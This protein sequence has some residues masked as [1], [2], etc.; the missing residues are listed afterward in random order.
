[1]TSNMGSHII[2]ENF[3]HA[4]KDNI[5]GVVESTKI[6]V[7]DLLKKTIR[8]EFLNRIDE[9]IMFRP[10][11]KN[12]IESIVRIQ[13]DN[14]AKM[15]S[16][17][18]VNVR[19]TDEVVSALAAQGYEPEFGARPLK[20]VLQREVINQLSKYILAGKVDRE[21]QIVIDVNSSG[22]IVFENAGHEL[23]S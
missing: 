7:M 17:T 1:M 16:E 21:A 15:L 19:F 12:S 3:A 23:Q 11:D 5:F 9:I 4:D 13:I 18:G 20:R 22:R 6:E 10:L 2:R 8:P 14:L